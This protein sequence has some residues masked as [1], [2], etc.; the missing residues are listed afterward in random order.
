[1]RISYRYLTT[2]YEGFGYM[3]VDRKDIL[4]RYHASDS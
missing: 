3:P 2:E 4:V 1:M